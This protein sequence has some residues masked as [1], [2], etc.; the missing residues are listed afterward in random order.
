MVAVLVKEQSFKEELAWFFTDEFSVHPNL[1]TM[2]ADKII[3]KIESLID[4]H[5]EN[6]QNFDKA[7][8]GDITQKAAIIAL[9]GLKGD[10]K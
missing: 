3:K 2:Y 5:I 4:Q 6:F 9:L 8:G 10:L 7:V 1:N